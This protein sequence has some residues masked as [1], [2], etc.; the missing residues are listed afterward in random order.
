MNY[1]VVQ[2]RTGMEEDFVKADKK[3]NPNSGEEYSILLPRRVL[4]IKRRGK[5][6][7]EISPVFKGYVF[8]EAE[9]LTDQIYS[10]LKN[11]KGFY[12]V[13]PDNKDRKA[14][15]GRDLDILNHFIRFDCLA[16]ISVAVFDENDRIKILEGPLMGLEGQIIKVD[17]RK[18]RAKVLLD[19]YNES[20]PIDFAFRALDL[21]QKGE[22]KKNVSTSK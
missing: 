7:K 17:R 11:V 20:F 19:A 10:L 3:Q 5:V 8:V 4:N 13:L 16:D 2:V 15:Y 18:G 9:E 12:R 14:L 1:Y 6:F 21:A 22:K